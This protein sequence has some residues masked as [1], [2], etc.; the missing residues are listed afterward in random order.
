MRDWPVASVMTDRTF[1]ISA[2]LAAST[3]T[4]G[5]TP[6][7]LYLTTPVIAACAKAVDGTST[8]TSTNRRAHEDR[9]MRFGIAVLPTSCGSGRTPAG[10]KLWSGR[11]L[12]LPLDR[13]RLVPDHEIENAVVAGT[14]ARV[15][16]R[17]GVDRTDRDRPQIRR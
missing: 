7:E 16:G 2:G 11:I 13:V 1:S 9:W 10:G 4:P 14:A 8:E 6:P 17:R 12:H 5:S 15:V 3:L